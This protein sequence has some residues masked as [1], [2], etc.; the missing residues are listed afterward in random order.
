MTGLCKTHYCNITLAEYW[1]LLK[2]TDSL[3]KP[4][5]LELNDQQA[6]MYWTR[7]MLKTVQW[8]RN[9]NNISHNCTCN[10]QNHRYFPTF[11][12]LYFTV[13]LFCGLVFVIVCQFSWLWHHTSQ[14]DFTALYRPFV[15]LSQNVTDSKSCLCFSE[16]D[17]QYLVMWLYL[18]IVALIFIIVTFSLLQIHILQSVSYLSH[19]NFVFAIV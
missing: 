5:L 14:C 17:L 7:L 9:C 11:V 2:S 13:L 19:C 4:M 3:F 1:R 18:T 12:T 10:S 6:H 8:K 15:I 16:L